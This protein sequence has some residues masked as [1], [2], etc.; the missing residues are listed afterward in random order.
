M[1]HGL[2]CW[3]EVLNGP[4]R[5]GPFSLLLLG[6]LQK[7]DLRALFVISRR[8]VFERAYPDY[9]AGFFA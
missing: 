7:S 4:V 5:T 1:E 6:C 9:A 8:R 3:F 2:E